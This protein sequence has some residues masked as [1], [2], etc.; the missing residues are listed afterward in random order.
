[1]ILALT[2]SR[3][4][5]RAGVPAA[6]NAVH[7]HGLPHARPAILPSAGSTDVRALLVGEKHVGASIEALSMTLQPARVHSQPRQISTIGDDD[8]HVD[9][10]GI[11]LGG[12]D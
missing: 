7:L 11:L 3:R 6:R 8:K 5:R 10:L 12:N 2:T 4:G 9:V 1:M